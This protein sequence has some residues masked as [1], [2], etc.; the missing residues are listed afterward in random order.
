MQMQAQHGNMIPSPSIYYGANMY[1]MP[2]YLP[3]Y[4]HPTPMVPVS[5]VN[6]K[7]QYSDQRMEIEHNQQYPQQQSNIT[8]PKHHRAKGGNG[9]SKSNRDIEDPMYT[10][11]RLNVPKDVQQQD[12]DEDVRTTIMIKNIPNKYTQKMLLNELNE[13]KLSC[14]K[15]DFFY[16]P[17]D[18]K[19]NC[20]VGYAFINFINHEDV[21]PYVNSI[22]GQKWREFNSSKICLCVYARVQGH[23]D[24]VSRFKDSSILEKDDMYKPVVFYTDGPMKGKQCPFPLT[25]CTNENKIE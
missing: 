19:N 10:I 22:Y 15:F 9:R 13:N 23:N 20:N 7:Q 8:R 11:H 3:Q 25:S 21:I 17:I 12:H 4:M 24:M 1:V 18:F 5:G 6:Y 16:L 14:N 2:Q